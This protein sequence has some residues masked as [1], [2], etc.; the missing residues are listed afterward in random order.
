MRKSVAAGTASSLSK[1]PLSLAGTMRVW[2]SS[3]GL[4][5][6]QAARD[7]V[8]DERFMDYDFHPGKPIT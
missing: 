1:R 5:A 4:S 6:A 7:I 2:R 8:M 3:R